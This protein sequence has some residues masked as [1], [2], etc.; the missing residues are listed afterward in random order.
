MVMDY[1]FFMRAKEF[2]RAYERLPNSGQPP[3][4][5]KYVLLYHAVELALKAYL[6]RQGMSEEVLRSKKFGHNLKKLLKE[7]VRRGLTLSHGSQ[8]MLEGL[9]GQPPDLPGSTLA[10]HIRIRYPGS[11][12]V[13]SLGQFAGAI[14]HLFTAM[15]E[16]AG[17]PP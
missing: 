8:E 15:V 3:E 17:F 16:Q 10:A 7:A 9:G 2:R 4:W 1:E 6:L 5:P 14:E 12:A 11:V 13:F